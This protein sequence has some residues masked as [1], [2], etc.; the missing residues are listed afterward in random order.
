VRRFF[1]FVFFIGCAIRTSAQT[2]PHFS[3][4]YAYPLWM[5]PGMTGVMD[6]S[7]RITGIYRNQWS[8]VMTPFNTA[9]LSID[10]STEKNLNLGANFMSQSAGDAGYKY[11][12]AYG[13]IAYSGIKF[14]QDG[15][16]RITTG[17]QVGLLSRRFDPA[18]FQFGDQWN[19]ITGYNPGA[20]TA[21][22]INQTSS[23][24]LDIGA[25][26]SYFDG[27]P[28]K[29]VNIFGGVAAFHL[30]RPED[31]F[32]N[33]G[34]KKY[35][36]V[37]Y[38]FHAGGRISLTEQLSLTPNIL[39]LKQGSASEKMVGLF[40]QMTVNDYTDLL[41]GANYRLGDAISPYAGVA[42]QH[43][44]LGM[45]YDVNISELGKAVTGTNSI[46]V[47]FTYIGRKSG[48]PLRYLSCPRF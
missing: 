7:F 36:P 23:S 34:S 37:R 42:F 1:C 44:V 4:F 32:V 25:G 30:T 14:G 40:G 8:E 15:N 47:S 43:F 28:D 18:K 45:S 39:Y 5:N 16:Q 46:E 26:L 11:L 38:S 9:G 13:S 22:F 21:D 31:P 27:T 17:I 35:L 12:N 2:D 48:K 24:V 19:P 3:Q 20:T 10:V 6:G 33:S 29:K 41:F